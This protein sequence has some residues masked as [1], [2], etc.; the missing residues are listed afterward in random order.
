MSFELYVM[1]VAFLSAIVPHI[2]KSNI[3]NLRFDFHLF[4]L[5]IWFFTKYVSFVRRAYQKRH[6]QDKIM[7]KK[8]R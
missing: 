4:L 7:F 6:A 1:D 8:N 3:Q 5:C 2:D